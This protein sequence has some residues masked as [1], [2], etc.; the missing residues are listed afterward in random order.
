MKIPYDVNT[1]SKTCLQL[2]SNSF[3][4]A[5]KT[6]EEKK[7]EQP[8]V[9]STKRASSESSLIRLRRRDKLCFTKSH[10]FPTVENAVS[11]FKRKLDGDG[12][13]AVSVPLNRR[14]SF[15]DNS[16]E[17]RLKYH[18]RSVDEIEKMSHN[19]ERLRTVLDEEIDLDYIDIVYEANKP[20]KQR[21]MS[22]S[23]VPPQMPK[24]ATRTIKLRQ[25][26]DSRESSAK[27]RNEESDEINMLKHLQS[28]RLSTS[29]ESSKFIENVTKRHIN[30]TG[31]LT[32]NIPWGSN[33]SIS[34]ETRKSDRTFKSDPT[35][36]HSKTETRRSDRSF[37]TD[38]IP[39]H[40]NTAHRLSY[41]RKTN[42]LIG[43]VNRANTREMQRVLRY[44]KYVNQA[45]RVKDNI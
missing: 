16:D 19:S 4:A 6:L 5:L 20:T 41:F 7:M 34:L 17:H 15:L 40:P 37:R 22:L 2:H 14:S 30:S 3:D 13:V 18:H 25:P 23:C 12:L 36:D 26:A 28:D 24:F 44:S 42:G 8:S 29:Q 11:H 10:D 39:E 38:H 45:F 31:Y 32:N 43:A 35:T 1:E 21:Y 9:R 27:E 33:N